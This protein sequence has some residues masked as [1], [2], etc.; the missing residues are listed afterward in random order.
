VRQGRTL[1]PPN[2]VLLTH[3]LASLGQQRAI[4]SALPATPQYSLYGSTAAGSLFM[5]CESG[6]LH[7]N[8]QH[9]HIEI[10]QFGEDLGRIVV[11]TLDRKLMPLL[12]FDL[13]DVVRLESGRCECGLSDGPQLIAVEG[14]AAD[15]L[16]VGSSV[17]TPAAI[18]R[19]IYAS[20]PDLDSWQL[21]RHGDRF[22]L[23]VVGATTAG[24]DAAG[25]LQRLL[26]AIVEVRVESAI[27]PESS[28][29]YRLVKPIENAA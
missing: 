14:R 8:R 16:T 10:I 4:R 17:I 1:A 2:F 12:R 20:E 5:E 21:V 27:L 11:T 24:R 13:G 28:G 22:Q 25:A 23:R 15:C 19:V 7:P 3:E 26:E 29:R 18:D 9:V 6:R